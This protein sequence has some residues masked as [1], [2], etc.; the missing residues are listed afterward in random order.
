M[1][2]DEEQQHT[3]VTYRDHTELPLQMTLQQRDN[4]LNAILQCVNNSMIT[5]FR[6]DNFNWCQGL[7][8]AFHARIPRC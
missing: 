4:D 3:F 8:Y 1:G 2:W 7:A 6:G 5:I